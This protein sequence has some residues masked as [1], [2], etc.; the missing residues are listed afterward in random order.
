MSVCAEDFLISAELKEGACEIDFRNSISRAYYA[1]F[2]LLKTVIDT[3]PNPPVVDQAFDSHNDTINKLLDCAKTTEQKV[4]SK[5]IINSIK[6]RK[7]MRKIADYELSQS[8]DEKD[9]GAQLNSV[10]LLFDD[11]NRLKTQLGIS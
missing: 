10:S 6:K 1:A 5:A 7:R 3:L 11:I 9:A 2:H 8:I 4:I